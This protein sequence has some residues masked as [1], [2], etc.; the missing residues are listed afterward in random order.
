[1]VSLITE[2]WEGERE[3]WQ[4]HI[5]ILIFNSWDQKIYIFKIFFF[6]NFYTQRGARKHNTEIKNH[7]L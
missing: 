4:K 7:M 1:M 5:D 2:G 3:Q 6:S